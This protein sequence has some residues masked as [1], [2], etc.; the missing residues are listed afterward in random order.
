MAEA[1]TQAVLSKE[2]VQVVSRDMQALVSVRA[3]KILSVTAA[4]YDTD[5]H[6]A[7]NAVSNGC[8]DSELCEQ[9]AH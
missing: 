1:H 9:N 2:V 5:A 6:S 7:E 3:N 8:V 4:D